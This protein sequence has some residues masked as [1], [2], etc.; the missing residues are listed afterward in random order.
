MIAPGWAHDF[1]PIEE[2][3]VFLDNVT[4]RWLREHDLF[5]KHNRGFGRS[6]SCCGRYLYRRVDCDCGN[7]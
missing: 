6:A 7:L 1:L 3:P 4:A 5:Q 2:F